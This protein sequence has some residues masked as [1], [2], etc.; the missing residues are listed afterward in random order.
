MAHET[1]IDVQKRRAHRAGE[2][3]VR[4]PAR[5]CH[6]RRRLCRAVEVIKENAAS[7]ARLVAVLQV[8]ILLAPGFVA[9]IVGH[10]GVR[11][12][13]PLHGGVEADCVR[14]VLGAAA[15]E[16]R[17]QVRPAA[18]PG[19]RGDDKAGVHVHGG[20]MGVPWMRDQRNA[21]G[22]EARVF[23]RARNLLGEFRRECAEH[24]RGVDAGFLKHP[25]MQHGHRAAA[26]GRAAVVA[27][28][29]G[30]AGEN[31]GGGRRA[32]CKRAGRVALKRLKGGNQPAL[33]RL[34]PAARPRLA[35]LNFSAWHVCFHVCWP[36]RHC[37]ASRFAALERSWRKASPKTMAAATATFSERMVGR[38]GMTMRACAAACT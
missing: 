29:P 6:I 14:V 25:A 11:L 23:I 4:L 36:Q 15:V 33:Q 1:R 18:K 10:P 38:M 35:P 9:R 37:P 19:A 31:T 2:G 3:E 5:S 27:A 24:G 7:A 26:A 34:E 12:A 20:H 28:A 13:R 22:P 21:R 30:F 32:G 16:H 8:K 17:R